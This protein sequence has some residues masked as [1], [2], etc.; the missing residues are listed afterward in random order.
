[1][2]WSESVYLATLVGLYDWL[3]LLVS[4]CLILTIVKWSAPVYLATLVGLYDWLPL[5]VGLCLYTYR[6]EMVCICVFSY[7]SWSV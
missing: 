1:M 6:C 2:S 3:P 4:L 7:I 5:L